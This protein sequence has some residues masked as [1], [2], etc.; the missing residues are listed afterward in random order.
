MKYLL[1]ISC[2]LFVLF[3][4][5][6]QDYLKPYQDLETELW[7]YKGF[8]TDTSLVPVIIKPKYK[9]AYVFYNGM[10]QVID[11]E[12]QTYYINEKEEK[13]S[14]TREEQ[15]RYWGWL[16]ET[17]FSDNF[18]RG[19]EKGYGYMD[20]KIDVS[21]RIARIGSKKLSIKNDPNNASFPFVTSNK[22]GLSFIPPYEVLPRA[23]YTQRRY[24]NVFHVNLPFKFASEKVEEYGF[25]IFL[26]IYRGMYSC[27]QIQ[28]IAFVITNTG[29]VLMFDETYPKEDKYV[30]CC[31][32]PWLGKQKF[33][34]HDF[35]KY[36]EIGRFEMESSGANAF[37]LIRYFEQ[38]QLFINNEKI[39]ITPLID[40]EI[41]Y[42]EGFVPIFYNKGEIKF[43]TGSDKALYDKK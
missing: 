10:A 22:S 39:F 43:Y 18:T 40:C 3:S 12:N 29:R 16:I 33:D 38:L 30:C 31:A 21:E 36:N 15:R 14:P 41:N 7:G 32:N 24:S 37:S 6:A 19:V 13:I 28:H 35:S 23:N 25:G 17:V 5:T 8:E 9:A 42:D 34:F 11:I 20:N 2:I 4:S 27:E 1:S 26:N